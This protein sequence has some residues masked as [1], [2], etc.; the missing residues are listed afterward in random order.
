MKC[1]KIKGHPFS[2]SSNIILLCFLAVGCKNEVEHKPLNSTRFY[3]VEIKDT[4]ALNNVRKYVI[5]NNIISNRTLLYVNLKR[6]DTGPV[7]Y[8]THSF[9]SLKYKL[10]KPTHYAIIDSS[11]A[12]LYGGD[13]SFIKSERIESEI[14]N[15]LLNKKVLLSKDYVLEHNQ[16]LRTQ[17]CGDKEFVKI[18]QYFTDDTPC[19]YKIENKNGKLYL[20][21]YK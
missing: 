7:I 9:N 12:L 5:K 13:E 6:T 16:I 14:E 19:G 10:V 8:I 4:F 21:K 1:L 11:I 20:S 15:V 17:L 18:D 3:E 2:H